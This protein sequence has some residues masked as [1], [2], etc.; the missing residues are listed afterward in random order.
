[1]NELIGYHTEVDA[2]K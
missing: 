2:K 1:L